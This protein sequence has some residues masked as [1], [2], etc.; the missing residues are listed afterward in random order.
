MSTMRDIFAGFCFTLFVFLSS[1]GCASENMPAAERECAPV[2]V[3]SSCAVDEQL[4]SCAEGH[5]PAGPVSR[6][7]S[8]TTWCTMWCTDGD[9]VK[10]QLDSAN[11]LPSVVE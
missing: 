8:A 6:Q 5:R 11:T 10:A 4:V 2:H 9:W 3:V 1:Q 7:D